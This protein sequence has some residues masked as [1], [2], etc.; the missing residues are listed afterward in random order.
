M[1]RHHRE[2]VAY[3]HNRTVPAGQSNSNIVVD[4]SQGEGGH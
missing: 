4:P 2:E 1:F 3:P